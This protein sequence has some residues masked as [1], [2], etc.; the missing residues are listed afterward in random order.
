VS[1]TPFFEDWA[2]FALVLLATELAASSV[3]EWHWVLTCYAEQFV[4]FY[5]NQFDADRKGLS[6]LYVWSHIR[7]LAWDI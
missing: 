3:L 6:A 1:S 7:F 5:Y 2:G 4:E